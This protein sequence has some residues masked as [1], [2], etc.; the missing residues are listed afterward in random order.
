MLSAA[1][2]ML[3][4]K[5]TSSLRRVKNICICHKS[6]CFL[7]WSPQIDREP[8][9]AIVTCSSSIVRSHLDVDLQRQEHIPKA[10]MLVLASD[11]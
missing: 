2:S 1:A 9:R 6:P 10:K 7:V 11:F 5:S 3:R 8:S 4:F